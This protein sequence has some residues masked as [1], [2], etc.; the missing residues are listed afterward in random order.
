MNIEKSVK[1]ILDEIKAK[2]D[3]AVS[4][5]TLKFDKKKLSP[6]HFKIPAS[7][8]K[9][10]WA[11]TPQNIKDALITAK[12]NIEIFHSA[13]MP[14]NWHIKPQDGTLLGQIF[15]PIERIGVYIP[16]GTAPLVSTVLMT[17]IP[18]KVAGVKEIILTTPP[19]ANNYILAAAYI[20]GATSVYQIGGA[21][22]IGALTYGTKTIPKVDKIVGPG[23]IYVTTAKKMVFGE[24]NIDMPA[25]PSEISIIAD[26]TAEPDFIALD[27]LSQLEHDPLSKATLI[28]TQAKNIKYCIEK[29]I[30][31]LKRKNIISKQALKI[32]KVSGLEQAVRICNNIAPE[33]LELIVKNPEKLIPKIKN[34][35]IIL[36]GPYTP[37]ALSDFLAGTNHVLPTGGAAKSFSGLNTRDFLKTISILKYNKNALCKIKPFVKLFSEIEKLDAH[38]KSVEIR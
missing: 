3:I 19:F 21:Q 26:N 24:V 23:N 31:T 29:Q 1:T 4:K 36:I 35:G 30:K 8:L 32:I 38:G 7:A 9:K 22:A 33:H 28:T 10:A 11:K 5:Y 16:G 2:G 25:G 6:K 27:L 18:A 12:T 15:R 17:V 20:A 13:Q 14:I 37:V 34:A